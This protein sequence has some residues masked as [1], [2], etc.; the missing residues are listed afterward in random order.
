MIN[1]VK[2][3]GTKVPYNPERINSFLDFVCEGLNCHPSEIALNANLSIYDG[4]STVDI[5]AALVESAQNLITVDTPDYAIAAARIVM[6]NL[7]KEVYG[8]FE[9][10]DLYTIVKD[11]ISIG[12]Y[13]PIILEKYTK[14]EIDELDDYIDHYRDF[15]FSIAGARE[16]ES[17][18]MSKNVLTGQYFETPQVAYMLI[19]A[20]YFIEDPGNKKWSR[21]ALVKRMYDMMSLGIWNTPT[22]HTARLRTPTRAFSSCVLLSC[23][24]SIP[25]ISETSTAARRYATL[26]A[27]IGVDVSSLRGRGSPIRNGLAM[28]TGALYHSKAIEESALSCSQGGGIRK[29]SLTFNWW[30]LHKD[31][32]EIFTYKN[33]MKKDSES[34]KHSDHTIFMNGHILSA[35]ARDEDIYLFDPNSS[36]PLYKAFY[37]G[38]MN[39]YMDE[40]NKAVSDGT[41]T[42]KI[43]ARSYMN[44]FES[45]RMGTGRMYL[46]FAD[47]IN[48]SSM[49]D[50]DKYP[51]TQSNLCVEIVLPTKPLDRIYDIKTK[52]YTQEGL[53]ALCNLGGINWG[54]IDS[55]EEFEEIAY[56]GLRA[57]DNILSYQEHPFPAAEEHNELFRPV[58]IGITGFAYWLAK[59]D[60]KYSNCYETLDTWMQHFSYA[61]ISAS[62]QLAEER[63]PCKGWKDT[64][65]SKGILPF[66][67]TTKFYEDWM[68][69]EDKLDWDTLR[70]KLVNTGIRNA[71]LMALFPAETSAKISGSGTTSGIEPIR[72]LIIQRGGKNK[73]AKFV[74][75]E[76]ARLKDKYERVWDFKDNSAYI[77]TCGVFQKYVDQ[78]ISVNTYYDKTNYPNNKIPQSV[79]NSD[80][81]L[82]YNLGG[83]TLYYNNNLDGQKEHIMDSSDVIKSDITIIADIDDDDDCVACKL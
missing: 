77:R 71:S 22:P 20:M 76:L 27:G 78:A 23:G 41:Y 80:I 82:H 73:Q 14:E 1:V 54:S 2:R 69:H 45:E 37:S 56:V 31:I 15:N 3:D 4:I 9:P 25:S 28:N 64:K 63:G 49:F 17:K 34:I 68:P 7:R 21:I 35:A 33:N 51:V 44:I 74:V 72:E 38:D 11:N 47:N 18:Y 70:A 30:G 65:W 24:D 26:G 32:E 79:V 59:N 58:G 75:P 40:Y 66:D 36:K 53:I 43:S 42:S 8:D 12:V 60:L 61:I 67:H 62:N 55:P 52:T 13:D 83:K 39:R 5:N 57:I 48:R 16:L 46:A 10:L 19:A 6:C 29:G 50:S 81:Y